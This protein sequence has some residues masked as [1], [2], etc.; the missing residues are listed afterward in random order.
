M[1]QDLG[2]RV[3]TRMIGG[4]CKL[5]CICDD[6]SNDVDGARDWVEFHRNRR[7]NDRSL[8]GSSRVHQRAPQRGVQTVDSSTN[9]LEH[10]W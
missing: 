1:L 3:E 7:R 5:L 2:Q 8:R 6:R 10:F 9:R 4:R